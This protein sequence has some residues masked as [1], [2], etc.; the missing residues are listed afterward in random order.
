M[1]AQF[2][3][4]LL[5]FLI[6][7]GYRLLHLKWL[8]ISKIFPSDDWT[9]SVLFLKSHKPCHSKSAKYQVWIRFVVWIRHFS[10]KAI[11]CHWNSMFSLLFWSLFF[12]W[13]QFLN[14]IDVM[15]LH[16]IHTF[17][18]SF[19]LLFFFSNENV[20]GN[21]IQIIIVILTGTILEPSC[22]FDCQKES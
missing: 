16:K 2:F 18:T 9:I 21:F 4:R 3:N 19:L 17:L 7:N 13:F 11:F 6:L 1:P 10:I 22:C 15:G 20:S 14:R 5:H 12:R 8:F